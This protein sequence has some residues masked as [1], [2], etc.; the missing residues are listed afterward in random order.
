MCPILSIIGED[1]IIRLNQLIWGRRIHVRHA[2]F[3]LV[4]CL[5]LRSG[6]RSGLRRGLRRG[7]SRSLG[8]HHR[9][10]LGRHHRDTLE[11]SASA[12]EAAANG[13]QQQHDWQQ[14][15][16]SSNQHQS[17]AANGVQQQH[18]WQQPQQQQQPASIS[19]HLL[20]CLVQPT[21]ATLQQ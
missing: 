8:R 7:T 11:Q 4:L 19:C 3:S 6:L 2:R 18:D 12:A 9:D 16:Q 15:H 21:I 17:T 13:V 1:V 20:R 5:F 10:T 14:L